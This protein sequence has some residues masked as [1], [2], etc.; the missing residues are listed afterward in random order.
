MNIQGLKM[1]PASFMQNT[2]KYE[3]DDNIAKPLHIKNINKQVEKY[4]Y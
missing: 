3:D 4:S 1:N 2:T